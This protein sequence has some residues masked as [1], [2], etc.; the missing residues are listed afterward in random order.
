M[1]TD[2]KTES[3]RKNALKSTGPKTAAGKAVVSRNAR[4]HGFL[5]RCII[6]K[7]ESQEEFTELLRLL[8]D[9]FQPVGLV[10]HTLVE[11]VG[12]AIWRQRRLVQA[13]S[14][15]I[16]LNQQS[17][18]QQQQEAVGKALNL[19]DYESIEAPKDG[20]EK[21]IAHLLL[22]KKMWQLLKDQKI[23]DT[24]DPFSHLSETAQKIVLDMFKAQ[25]A[26]IDSDVKERFGSWAK[27]FE[28]QVL[29]L[30][31]LI[32]QQRICEV[33]KLVMQ[34]QALPSKTDLLSRYQ[35]ALDNDFYKAL[36]A[37]R[38]S[39]TWRQSQAL[40]SVKPVCPGG[41]GE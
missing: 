1:S 6:I 4:T 33:S 19:A 7:G 36:K 18:G 2:K 16:S 23:A 37:L 14:A 25:P 32:K 10:E 35:T 20:G 24:D 15:E 31:D 38:E 41:G 28:V 3:N 13:E 8:A 30:E 27:M 29:F 12:I 26:R 9:E 5:S 22:Q 21:N 11:R 40:I 34:R 17:F 39:Q